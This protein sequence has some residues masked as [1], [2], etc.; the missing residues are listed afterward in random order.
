[1]PFDLILNKDQK[2]GQKNERE[3]FICN[4]WKRQLSGRI[5]LCP[6]SGKDFEFRYRNIN[7]S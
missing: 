3:N 2:E 5:S 1:M 6:L 7:D 4:K